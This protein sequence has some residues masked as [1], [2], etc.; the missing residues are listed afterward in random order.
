MLPE[1]RVSTDEDDAV[2]SIEQQRMNVLECSIHRN[3]SR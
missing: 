1:D 2:R 3:A